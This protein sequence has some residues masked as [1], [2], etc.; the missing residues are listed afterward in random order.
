MAH[1]LDPVETGQ[2]GVSVSDAPADRALAAVN[3]VIVILS[4]IA[5]VLAACVLTYSVVVRYFL[6]YSTDWQDEMSVFLIVGA[7][8]M[9]AAAIQAQRGHI[10]IEAIVG[11]LPKR[12]N[13]V[14]ILLVDDY[15]SS[16]TWAPPLWIPYSL[17]T[18]GMVLLSVQLLLQVVA[19]LRAPDPAA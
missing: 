13:H 19:G 6:K 9:S 14:R 10:G 2:G 3:R 8:F 1:G 4:S 7:V 5:L 12:V 11:L 17:M 18:A 15:H 16:S